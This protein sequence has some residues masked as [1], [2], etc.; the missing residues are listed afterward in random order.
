VP[1]DLQK[2]KKIKTIVTH[3]NCSDGIASAVILKSVLPKA[4]VIF[5]QHGTKEQLS[6]PA[7]EGMIF[8][9][10]SPPS[11]RVQEF[12]DVG[13]IVLDHHIKQQG[14]V[15]QFGDN[16]V[17]AHETE[18]PGVS[19]AVLAYLEVWLPMVRSEPH[20][21]LKGVLLNNDV[22]SSSYP[23]LVRKFATLAGIRDTWQK[24]STDWN[25]ARALH[26]TLMF[27]GPEV[28]L[29]D[30]F[31][32][33]STDPTWRSRMELGHHLLSKQNLRIEKAKEGVFR[34]SVS[35]KVVQI[36]NDVTITSDLA[37]ATL[38]GTD[39]ILGFSYINETTDSGWPQSIG[40]K[41]IVSCRSRNGMDVGEFAKAHGGGGHSAAAGFSLQLK[42]GD[43]N[44]Y[45]YIL[46][47]VREY[48]KRA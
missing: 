35:G 46:N 37:E 32:S 34:T 36:H 43:P 31:P 13:A 41:I 4:D 10:F 28:W 16:G 19:G 14:I 17:F 3:A 12:L 2:V 26:E 9:D 24:S 22:G 44:P 7:T 1:L 42:E 6:I 39:F 30:L 25:E 47:L 15:A 18:N 11:T 45:S 33:D 27:Y 40:P 8:C 38:P 21:Y 5:L 23:L 48:L 20:K 29:T